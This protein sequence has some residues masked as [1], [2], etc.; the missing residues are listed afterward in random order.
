MGA[1]G[2]GVG[3][4]AGQAAEGAEGVG[5]QPAAGEVVLQAATLLQLQL[6]L[7]LVLRVMV[8]LLWRLL[9]QVVLGVVVLVVF[10]VVASGARTAQGQVSLMVWARGG[11]RGSEGSCNGIVD[12]INIML[13]L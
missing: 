5:G 12:T 13:L 6:Q 9:R 11:R 3:V 1:G 7:L 4:A 2:L 10:S 8:K